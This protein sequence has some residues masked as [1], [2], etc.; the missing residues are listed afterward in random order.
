MKGPTGI[1]RKGSSEALAGASV[2]VTGST[3]FIGSRLMEELSSAG[4][5]AVAIRDDIRRVIE[6]GQPNVVYHLAA[7]S[8]HSGGDIQGVNVKGTFN[9]LEACRRSD[10]SVVF[11]SS[12]SVYGVPEY[13]PVD[14][15]HPKVPVSEYGKS[16]LE[17]EMMIKSH[18]E[19]H[20]LKFT[21]LRLFNVYG[22][23]QTGSFLVPTIVSQLDGPKMVLRN[24]CYKRDFIHVD[25][26]V[27][28]LLR[29]APCSNEVLNIGSGTGHTARQMVEK[30]LDIRNA[31]GKG[32]PEVSYGDS[33]DFDIV[34][35]ITR[36]RDRL[37]WE[38]MI[39]IDAG[40]KGVM[41]GMS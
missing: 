37:G 5:N 11:A 18:A 23:G 10:T 1:S 13:I 19:Q 26:V 32:I 30:M 14:E 8:H 15:E 34:A 24:S 16:K 21:I 4:A 2:A 36:A 41:E 7:L 38:P 17:G 35:D 40:L 3:G 28:A 6:L 20:G 29:A 39:D 22:P 27:G 25:D 9:V 12:A 33:K 31:E